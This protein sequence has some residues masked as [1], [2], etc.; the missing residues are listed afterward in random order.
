MTQQINN[1]EQD[2][3]GK[4]S[5]VDIPNMAY[6]YIANQYGIGEEKSS[7]HNGQITKYKQ[8]EI[9]DSKHKVFVLF[10]EEPEVVARRTKIALL[11]FEPR[12]PAYRETYEFEV[13]A[14]KYHNTS[15][16]QRVPFN[17]VLKMKS[18]DLWL[19]HPIIDFIAKVL[20]IINTY[21]TSENAA[22]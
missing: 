13:Y 9:K 5:L 7:E 10:S 15:G 12:F 17:T 16:E 1:Q 22:M 11:T 4:Y 2:K 19:V 8:L 18:K 20:P 14:D 3:S 21:A 6:Q